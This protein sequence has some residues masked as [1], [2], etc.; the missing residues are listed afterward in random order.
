M[1]WTSNIQLQNHQKHEVAFTEKF[2]VI[3]N[4][5]TR[6]FQFCLL[7]FVVIIHH[8]YQ[9]I[10]V[11]PVLIQ[12]CITKKQLANV[13][14]CFLC[15]QLVNLVLYWS[16]HANIRCSHSFKIMNHTAIFHV[17]A[18]HM[19][20]WLLM[21]KFL[22]FWHESIF[23][24]LI[25]LFVWYIK[26]MSAIFFMTK[27]ILWMWLSVCYAFYLLVSRRHTLQSPVTQ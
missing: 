16:Y 2:S 20:M 10:T 11:I 12:N 19:F 26:I 22:L 25:M 18:I 9:C 7:Q 23:M 27:S 1:H 17:D 3:Q 8:F 21:Y 14:L 5:L 6:I 24:V 15:F 4:I 13:T